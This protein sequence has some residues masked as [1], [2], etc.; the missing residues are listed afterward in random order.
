MRA[1]LEQRFITDEA[2]G[3]S[4]NEEQGCSLFP[5]GSSATVCTDY[6]RQVRNGLPGRVVILGFAADRN[7]GCRVAR[8]L[9]TGHDFAVVD[10]RW[11]VDGWIKEVAFA[12]D[13]AVFDMQDPR[14]AALV[15][16]WYGPRA[17]WE[18]IPY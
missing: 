11:L 15:L 7:P 14:D 2:L 8:D 3:V 12:L 10:N 9:G 16:E 13:K 1:L 6:A 17:L 4:Y 5:D 18:V